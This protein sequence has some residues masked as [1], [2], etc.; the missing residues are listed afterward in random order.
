VVRACTPRVRS[1]AAAGPIGTIG[2]RSAAEAFEPVEDQVETERE[3]DVAVAEV[4][5]VVAAMAMR[6]TFG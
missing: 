1:F 6:P 4:A 2:A 3:L 5:R